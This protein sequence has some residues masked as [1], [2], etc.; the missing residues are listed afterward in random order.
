MGKREEHIHANKHIIAS[1]GITPVVAEL[2]PGLGLI[3]I[4]AATKAENANKLLGEAWNQ[5]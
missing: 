4:F 1:H 5:V 3:V 2:E